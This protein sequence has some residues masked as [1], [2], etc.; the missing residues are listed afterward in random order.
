MSKLTKKVDNEW[1]YE[2]LTDEKLK[3]KY[4]LSTKDVI[5]IL[6]TLYEFNEFRLM[7]EDLYKERL[8]DHEFAKETLEK[9]KD[10]IDDND[11]YSWAVIFARPT[12][13]NI[14]PAEVVSCI[15]TAASRYRRYRDTEYFTIENGKYG[16]D[17]SVPARPHPT[18]EEFKEIVNMTVG[19]L[20]VLSYQIQGYSYEDN[21]ERFI[22][23]DIEE[24]INMRLNNKPDYYEV[25]EA[26]ED[27]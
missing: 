2:L 15:L 3:D 16:I 25:C 7:K 9:H 27:E 21:T 22:K 19:A 4:N 5:D 10:E 24:A 18:R 11:D 26:K 6:D 13:L 8:A 14:T 20:E 17:Y 12:Y 1:E 23:E